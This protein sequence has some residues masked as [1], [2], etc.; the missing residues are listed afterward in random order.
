MEILV[1]LLLWVLL[2][3]IL[4][5]LWLG[6]A[7]WPRFFRSLRQAEELGCWLQSWQLTLAQ[8]RSLVPTQE[9]PTYKFFGTLAATGLRH[10]RAFG[11]FPRELLWEWREGLAKEIEF[12]KR[13]LGLKHGAWGQFAL[14]VALTWIF[15]G[16]VGHSLGLGMPFYLYVVVMTLQSVGFLSFWPVMNL[17]AAKRLGAFPELLETLY[18]LRSLSHAGLPM[19]QVVKEARLERLER[20]RQPVLMGIIKRLKELVQLH[21]K[22]GYPLAHEVQALLQECWFLREEKLKAL[23]K[24]GESVKLAFLLVFFAGAYFIFLVGLVFQLLQGA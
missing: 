4:S 11:S 12:E 5:G 9:V 15:I 21:Q 16:I 13:W 14:F 6:E 3:W 19:G 23:G 7:V 24:L 18:V 2:A 1:P 22:Q 8:G 20:M 10:A 17:L